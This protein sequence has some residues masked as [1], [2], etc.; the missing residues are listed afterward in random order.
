MITKIVHVSGLGFPEGPVVMPD[1]SI[2]F[3]DLADQAI[4]TYRDG[5]VSVLCR[6]DGSPNG[7]QL[8]PDGD[9]YVCN[10]GGLKPHPT[11]GLLRAIPEIAGRIQRIDGDG[12]C[13]DF[14]VD[15]PGAK[16]S[17]PN[18]LVFSPE[19]DL[20]F[21][22]P[23]NWEAIGADPKAYRGG[24]LLRAKPDG[25]VDLLAPMDSF[26]N[27]LVFHPD[28]TLLVN[29]SM[30]NRIY[31]FDW[32]ARGVSNKREWH[33]FDSAFLPDGMAVAGD[34]VYVAGSMG[35]RVAVLNLEGR[36]LEMIDLGPGSDPTNLCVQARTLWVT[37]GF[38]GELVSLP[39]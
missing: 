39:I 3:V 2:A 4:R 1:G 26:P 5:A 9:L 8:G 10:N 35:D 33:C 28:G 12:I 25:K 11:H 37:L 24:Q 27:G 36:L 32:S 21:T 34:R 17:R 18:D 14:A 19:G 16:P 7:M 23:Q 20:I 30:S 6:V 22:D 31:Q 38:Q 13:H 15:L 29:T